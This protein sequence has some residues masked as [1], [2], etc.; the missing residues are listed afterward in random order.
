[1]EGRRRP[2]ALKTDS[3][4]QMVEDLLHRTGLEEPPVPMEQVARA[5]GVPIR[6][7]RLPVFFRGALVSE[8]G[9]P[10]IVIN[11]APFEPE[12]RD[13]LAHMLGHVLLLLN[14]SANGYP[15]DTGP[16][17][18]ADGIA[19]ELIMPT[20]LVIEQSQLWFNDYRYMARLFGVDEH[21]MINRMRDLGVSLGSQGALWDY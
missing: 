8:D 16:H 14:D 4:R 13:A 18:E 15:R 9:L 2:V 17:T 10:V 1:M 3:Y 11:V 20:K 6:L 21:T 5:L 19:T 7:V 12:R